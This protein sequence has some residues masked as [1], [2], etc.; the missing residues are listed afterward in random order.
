[1]R[2]PDS[3][4]NPYLALAVCLA[5]GLDG[6]KNKITPPKAVDGNIFDMSAE[7]MAALDIQA[8]PADLNEAI[9]EMEKDSF[10]QEVLGSHVSRKYAE[11]KREEWA[12]YRQQITDWEI[13]E[14]LYKI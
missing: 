7:E 4:A 11:A 13:N 9:E 12:A 5:A 14:Y 2:S 10:I 3:A 8:L 6:I 1:M